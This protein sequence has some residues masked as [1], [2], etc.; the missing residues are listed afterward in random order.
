MEPLV[1]PKRKS[2]RESEPKPTRAR[3]A[4]IGG[5][6]MAVPKEELDRRETEWKKRRSKRNS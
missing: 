2:V 3:F 5:R 1:K 6:I 4:N